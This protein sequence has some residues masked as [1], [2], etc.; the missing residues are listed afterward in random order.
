[1]PKSRNRNSSHPNKRKAIERIK[2]LR[3]FYSAHV[4]DQQTLNALLFDEPD[5]F[6]RKAMFDFIRPHLKFSAEFPSRIHN[7][8]YEIQPA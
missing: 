3:N 2:R 5:P 6:K 7:P 8:G 4:R 1:M